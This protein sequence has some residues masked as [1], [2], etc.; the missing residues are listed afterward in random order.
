MKPHGGGSDNAMAIACGI[1]PKVSKYDTYLMAE[2]AVD[3]AVR[4]AV[5]VGAN[6]DE[7]V[8][9]DNYCWPDPIASERNPDAA[10]KLAQLVRASKGL[11]DI[12]IAYGMP[13]VSG[14]DSMKNDFIGMNEFQEKIK[15]SVPPTLLITSL[16]KVPTLS[17]ITTSEIK[18]SGDLVYLIGS[19]LIGF[20]SAFELDELYD[21]YEVQFPLPELDT[22]KQ[23]S[24]YRQIHNAMKNNLIESAH[25]ISD[26]GLILALAEKMMG[27]PMGIRISL[28]L[29]EFDLKGFLFNESAGRI[30]VTVKPSNELSFEALLNGFD[31]TLLGETTNTG[32]LVVKSNKNE[33]LKVSGQECLENY[34]YQVGDF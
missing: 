21:D 23:V 13:F 1:C 32:S 4:N 33:I 2:Y 5:C 18:N 3:E 26:G 30:L 15:I 16:G 24:M 34:K 11:Y 10:L 27:T 25:D 20:N 14:K 28:D 7:M 22:K 29:N 9:V 8:L 19:N 6:P 17:T 12:S 31:F